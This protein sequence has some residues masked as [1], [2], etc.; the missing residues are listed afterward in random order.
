M[1]K[2]ILNDINICICRR[3]TVKLTGNILTDWLANSIVNTVTLLFKNVI[4]KVIENNLKSALQDKIDEI[5][6][7]MA[8]SHDTFKFEMMALEYIR[9]QAQQQQQQQ[10]IYAIPQY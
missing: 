5:N 6:S 8:G 4:V 7:N 2:L 3:I 1:I 10:Q 9:L